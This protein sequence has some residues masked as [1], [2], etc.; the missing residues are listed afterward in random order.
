MSEPIKTIELTEAKVV[1]NAVRGWNVEQFTPNGGCVM[2]V[3]VGICAESR[4]KLYREVAPK[5]LYV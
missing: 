1:P 3:F 5:C 4:A 2:A